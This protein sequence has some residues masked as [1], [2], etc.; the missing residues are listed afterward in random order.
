MPERRNERKMGG[1]FLS[2]ALHFERV[3]KKDPI[4]FSKL[5]LIEKMP[6]SGEAGW[7]RTSSRAEKGN[8]RAT[9]TSKEVKIFWVIIVCGGGDHHLFNCLLKWISFFL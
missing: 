3:R 9:K 5:P 7:K 1:E 6:V 8:K 2:V 4:N